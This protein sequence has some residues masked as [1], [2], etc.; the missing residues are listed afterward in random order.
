MYGAK[1][2]GRRRYLCSKYS[3]SKAQQCHHHF[4][5][6]EAVVK[7]ALAVLRQRVVQ[8]GGR[9]ELRN[10]LTKLAMTE[11]GSQVSN[12]ERDLELAEQRLHNLEQDL[13]IISKN[14]ARADELYP[15]L[16]AEYESVK[17]EI[18]QHQQRLGNLRA[19]VE[20]EEDRTSPEDQVGRALALLDQL[21]RVA[22]NPEA[23][24]ELSELLAK[25]DFLIAFRFAPN[26]PKARPSR[27]PVGGMITIGNPESPIRM[28]HLH[29]VRSPVA[30][31]VA[32][33]EM[34]A[35]RRQLSSVGSKSRRH[36][37][38]LGKGAHD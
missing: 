16:K 36:E 14:L 2:K 18:D 27:I 31:G 22:G 15:V 5:D 19:Q 6:A 17:R 38:G 23:R 8:L 4:V 7:F 10:R 12:R 21:E 1:E 37:A 28:E 29:G 9:A 34:P 3:E 32:D 24:E 11:G 13:R 33:G 35:G 20:R 30:T 25:L 26:H